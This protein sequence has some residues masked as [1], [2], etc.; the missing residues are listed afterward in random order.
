MATRNL[1]H[2][3]GPLKKK[4]EALIHEA[5]AGASNSNSE[6]IFDNLRKTENFNRKLMRNTENMKFGLL[7][8]DQTNDEPYEGI[9][10]LWELITE[11][12]ALLSDL[13][14]ENVLS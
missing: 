5:T 11:A 10:D 2:R 12:E 6:T 14:G 9:G 13:E 1:L 4:F 8:I 3:I 7:D